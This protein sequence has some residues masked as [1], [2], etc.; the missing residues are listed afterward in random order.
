[1]EE[2]NVSL[3]KDTTEKYEHQHSFSLADILDRGKCLLRAADI[4]SSCSEKQTNKGRKLTV[5]Q[6]LHPYTLS[7]KP[8]LSQRINKGT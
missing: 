7:D 5:K 6:N 4:L 1:M 2:K 3:E 8:I